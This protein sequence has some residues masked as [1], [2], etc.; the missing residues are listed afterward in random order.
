MHPTTGLEAGRGDTPRL[1]VRYAAL[2][3]LGLVRSRNEDCLVVDGWVAQGA[4]HS[5]QGTGESIWTAAVLDGLGGHGGGDVASLL[6]ASVLAEHLRTLDVN[7]PH[8]AYREVLLA[9]SGRIRS[10]AR[11]TS[12]LVGMGATAVALVLGYDAYTVCNIG[13]ARAYRVYQGAYL[14]Q[15]SID[16][17]S[18]AVSNVVTQALGLPLNPECDV[19]HYRLPLDAP[20]LI[21]L[22]SD[23]LTDVVGDDE[24]RTA[25][26]ALPSQPQADDLATA[27]DTLLELVRTGGAPD[28]VTMVLVAVE[29]DPEGRTP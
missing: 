21:L 9:A 16:D 29:P 3:D 28:N 19:H 26:R 8:Q 12:S 1:T 23:G 10:I 20:T 4:H 18:S 6:G 25:L 11:D 22:C 27:L 7:D 14:A 13:D 15:L 24:L 17:R 5:Y 2:T